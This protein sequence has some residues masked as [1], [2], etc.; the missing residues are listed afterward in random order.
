MLAATWLIIV[1]P[2]EVV[3]V[4]T[5]CVV[6]GL[7]VVAGVVAATGAVVVGVTGCWT[8]GVVWWIAVKKKCTPLGT[9]E[10]SSELMS[11]FSLVLLSLK[12]Y[13]HTVMCR[14]L[15]IGWPAQEASP[16]AKLVTQ[17]AL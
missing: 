15:S 14:C 16:H 10:G 7:T 2:C 6:L 4:T 5:C 17:L 11:A 13:L 3:V 9:F 1:L 12:W 8:K